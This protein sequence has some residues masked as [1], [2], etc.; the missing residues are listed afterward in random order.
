M[1]SSSLKTHG[2]KGNFILPPF[3]SGQ[4]S[5]DGLLYREEIP[6]EFPLFFLCSTMGEIPREYTPVSDFSVW[7]GKLDLP[8]IIAEVISQPN[9]QDP[10]R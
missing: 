9:E 4:Y 8:L 5:T 10:K 7:F 2:L 1:T 6:W 3:F